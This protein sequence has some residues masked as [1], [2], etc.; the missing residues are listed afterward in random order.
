MEVSSAGVDF[1]SFLMS[2]SAGVASYRFATCADFR[3]PLTTHSCGRCLREDVDSQLDSSTKTEALCE[4]KQSHLQAVHISMGAYVIRI[5]VE[6]M[7]NDRKFFLCSNYSKRIE[8]I[9]FIAISVIK[10]LA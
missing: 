5:R 1:V 9:H 4:V 2:R 7:C 6:S 8:S 3:I 10:C